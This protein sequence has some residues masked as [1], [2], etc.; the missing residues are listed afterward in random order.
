[1]DLS[2]LSLISGYAGATVGHTTKSPEPKRSELHVHTSTHSCAS[3]IAAYNTVICFS[4]DRPFQLSQLLVSLKMHVNGVDSIKVLYA[5]DMN[6]VWDN[7]Y[8]AIKKAFPSVQ[9][10][11]ECVGA[12]AEAILDILNE[13]LK[14]AKQLGRSSFVTFCVDDLIFVS[15]LDLQLLSNIM[16]LRPY[17]FATHSKLHPGIIF[18]HSAQTPCLPP[19]L[20]S[21]SRRDATDPVLLEFAVR[22]PEEQNKISGGRADWCYPFDLCG[23]TYRTA[24]VLELLR[25]CDQGS[26]TV[27]SNNPQ[28]T[29]KKYKYKN[30]NLLET[31]GNESFWALCQANTLM[32]GLN[33]A[34]TH[35]ICLGTHVLSVLTVNRVQETYN[36]PIY[37]RVGGSGAVDQLNALTTVFKRTAGKQAELGQYDGGE[38]EVIPRCVLDMA[39][40]RADCRIMSVHIGALYLNRECKCQPVANMPTE[41]YTLSA[42]QITNFSKMDLFEKILITLLIPVYNSAFYLSDMM[43]SLYMPQGVPF[44]VLIVDDG[45]SDQ[46]VALVKSYLN[47]QPLDRVPEAINSKF[48][49]AGNLIH[50]SLLKA[51]HVG[52]T[53]WARPHAG[54]PAA[55]DAGLALCATPFVARLDADDMLVAGRLKRQLECM[56]MNPNL[57]IIGAQALVFADNQ[58]NHEECEGRSDIDI[59]KQN[60]DISIK[61]HLKAWERPLPL[62][63]GLPVHPMLVQWELLF[64]CS[65]IHPSVMLRRETVLAAGGYV[66]C[67]T[68]TEMQSEACHTQ[69]MSLASSSTMAT[70]QETEE[71]SNLDTNAQYNPCEDYRLW[72]EMQRLYPFC[73]ANIPDVGVILRQHAQSKSLIEAHIAA[74]ASSDIRVEALL[75]LWSRQD[76]LGNPTDEKDLINTDIPPCCVSEGETD[77]IQ[78]CQEL[79]KHVP[80]QDI[81]SAWDAV[82]DPARYL[83]RPEQVVLGLKLLS[84]AQ[85]AILSQY[86]WHRRS[87]NM[88]IFTEAMPISAQKAVS[89]HEKALKTTEIYSDF[90][91]EDPAEEQSMLR[92]LLE[93]SVDIRRGKVLGVAAARG[94]LPHVETTPAQ[95]HLMSSGPLQE[96]AASAQPLLPV[97]QSVAALKETLIQFALH[98]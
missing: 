8:E 29:Q 73:M 74:D 50:G 25:H 2:I 85:Q 6:S 65:V 19:Y 22:Q 75:S 7:D 38:E 63:L 33:T 51:P 26:D 88:N 32:K 84:Y 68:R 21:L 49:I 71:A 45:S 18:S 36:V 69:S 28:F 80:R 9:F 4:K 79:I 46:S 3:T 31:V 37:N 82:S 57:S 76:S 43:E 5:C 93:Q 10:M 12:F 86:V 30:P 34:W 24:D 58:C 14:V 66:G 48:P 47:I 92:I 35:C 53:V 87:Q 77:S 44:H 94:L 55:L 41:V 67:K 17:V 95:P 96:N 78:A 56:Q 11:R 70:S 61:R 90:G 62:A 97:T 72:G 54:L 83:Q 39:A 64:R 15:Q 16:Q 20:E 27:T 52:C 42:S 60:S 13:S 91:I 59:Q 1:M 89:V 81:A 98:R 40:Y 23:S